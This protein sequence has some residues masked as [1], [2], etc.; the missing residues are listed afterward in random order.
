MFGV[1]DGHGV[2]GHLVSNFV[3]VNLPK[4]I[5]EKVGQLKSALA[6]QEYSQL[7]EGNDGFL[8]PIGNQ[9]SLGRDVLTGK[10]QMVPATPQA[11]NPQDV[12]G[13]VPLHETWFRNP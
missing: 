7:A 8:P 13:T 6:L 11:S 1:N 3:K 10:R 5:T 12:D 2:Q 4:I 9:R